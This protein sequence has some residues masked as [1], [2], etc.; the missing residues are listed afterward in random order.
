MPSALDTR[1]VL[2]AASGSEADNRREVRLP[3]P[4]LF[5]SGI[6]ATVYDVSLGGACLLLDEELTA[7]TRYDLI[8]TDGVYRY[9]VDIQAEVVWCS[10]GRAGLRWVNVTARQQAWLRD[11][12]QAWL[13]EGDVR[14]QMTA[15]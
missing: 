15:A 4:P 8:L 12:S 10:G 1:A 13:D 14:L 5:V 9:T 2:P 6:W 7:G 11:R 3:A